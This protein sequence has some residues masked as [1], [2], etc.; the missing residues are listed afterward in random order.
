MCERLDGAPD[1]GT[2]GIR[3]CNRVEQP[4]VAGD[5]DLRC[6]LNPSRQIR[7]HRHVAVRHERAVAHQDRRPRTTAV[8]PRPGV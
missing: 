7:R 4:A 8:M 3:D 5:K 2:H 1:F 6:S